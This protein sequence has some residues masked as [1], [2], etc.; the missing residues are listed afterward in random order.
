MVIVVLM[1]AFASLVAVITSSLVTANRMLKAIETRETERLSERG[2]L[3]G[4]ATAQALSTLAADNAYSD[5]DRLLAKTAQEDDQ[6]VLAAYLTPAETVWSYFGPGPP[7][8]AKQERWRAI[9]LTVESGGEVETR[10]RIAGAPALVR[11]VPV[12]VD[13]EVV[14]TVVLGL[15]TRGVDSAIGDARH[16]EIVSTATSLGL[17]MIFILAPASI[18]VGLSR[19]FARALTRPL[20]ELTVAASQVAGPSGGSPRPVKV[21]TSDAEVGELAIAFNTMVDRVG[22]RDRALARH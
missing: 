6:I 15:S 8:R 4:A 17:M 22:A 16:A 18:V 2:R 21:R 1:V 13:L 10:A 19:R 14:G 11:Q 12:R 5:I 3:L 7:G 9:G 20:S